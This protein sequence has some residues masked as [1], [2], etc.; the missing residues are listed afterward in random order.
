MSVIVRTPAGQLRLYC[1]GAVSNYA[2]SWRTLPVIVST[3]GADPD[4]SCLIHNTCWLF[5]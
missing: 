2:A 5:V 4:I 3:A 1:K